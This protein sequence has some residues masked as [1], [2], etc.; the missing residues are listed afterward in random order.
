MWRR[1]VLPLLMVLAV[2]AQGA[3]T[4]AMYGGTYTNWPTAW[5]P[6]LSLNDPNDGVSAGRLDF[7]GDNT[8]PGAYWQSD[9]QYLYFRARVAATG[10][11]PGDWQDTIWVYVDQYGVGLTNQADY[12]FAWDT[13][14]RFLPGQDQEHGLEMEDKDTIGAAWKDVLMDDVDG[15]VAK[16][17]VPP[18]FNTNGN[19]YVRTIDGQ[20][21]TNFGTTTLIDFAIQWS[22]L[23][24]QTTLE[25][26]QTWR[27]QFGSRAESTDHTAPT[28]DIAGNAN[29]TSSIANWSTAF[30]VPEPAQVLVV[31]GALA[32][33]GWMRHRRRAL[34]RAL[35]GAR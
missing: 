5:F 18:D 4:N 31:L 34:R 7:V 19:G 9:G 15:D 12:A 2:S 29:P 17:I 32:S 30:V 3:T 27:I 16:K 22:Y 8:D 24:S 28:A 6:I 35:R 13:K 11:L 14:G 21:T 1:V 10:T 26:G 23:T 25:Q 20:A 33:I